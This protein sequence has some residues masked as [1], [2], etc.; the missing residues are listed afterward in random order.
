MIFVKRAG[1]RGLTT[2]ATVWLT[3]AIGLA[4]GAGLVVLAAGATLAHLIVSYV[5]TPLVVRL[6]PSR[7]ALTSVEVSYR[8]REGVLRRVLADTTRNGYVISDLDVARNDTDRSS[9]AVRFDVGGKRSTTDLV[10]SLQALDGVLE[11]RV[12]EAAE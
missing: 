1:V 12:G 7:R 9:V 10:E 6:P 2:A 11:V 5:Y 8:D 4:A 3:A